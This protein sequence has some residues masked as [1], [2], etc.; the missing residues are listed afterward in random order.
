MRE[1][2]KREREA[3]ICIY[4]CMEKRMDLVRGEREK[5]MEREMGGSERGGEI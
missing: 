2:R 4:V 1:I 3:E 5:G